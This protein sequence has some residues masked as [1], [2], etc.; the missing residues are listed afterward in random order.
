MTETNNL[1][2]QSRVIAHARAFIGTYGGL[3]YL[4]PFFGTPSI[5][6][7]SDEQDL[8]PVHRVTAHAAC[9]ALQGRLIDLDAADIPVLDFLL[10]QG[11]EETL[12]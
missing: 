4:G 1:D 5:G 7:Y 3:S 8:K 9:R 2:V 11:A 12:K 6:F 10:N